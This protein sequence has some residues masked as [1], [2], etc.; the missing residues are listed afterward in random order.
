MSTAPVDLSINFAFLLRKNF[1]EADSIDGYK[2]FYT[3]D[4]VNVRRLKFQAN[5]DRTLFYETQE[6]TGSHSCIFSDFMFILIIFVSPQLF[7]TTYTANLI[8]RA[9][10]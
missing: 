6:M 3:R 2:A 9:N 1:R 8:F 5:I 7:Q 4:K 10:P